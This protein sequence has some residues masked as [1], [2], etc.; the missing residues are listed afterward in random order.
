MGYQRRVHGDT[1]Q[2]NMLQKTLLLC[3]LAVA[4]ATATPLLS[5]G[6]N[7]VELAVATP[8]LS[9]LVTALKAGALVDTLSGEGPFTVFAPTNEAFAK[10]SASILAHLLDPANVK[11]LDAVLEYHVVAGAAVFSN[12]LTDGE[13]IKTVEGQNV[14]VSIYNGRVFI[15]NA[16]VTTADVAAS[17]GVIHIIDTVL[18][19]PPAPAPPASKNIVE[20][21]AASADFSTLV[22][23]LKA[24]GLVDYLSAKGPFTVFAPTNEA[25]AKLPAATLTHLLDPANMK[26]LDALLE[27]HVVSGVAAFVKDLKDEELIK[28]VEGD[29]VSIRVNP[30]GP[31]EPAV[32]I[33]IGSTVVYADIAASN[34]VIHGIDTVLTIPPCPPPAPNMTI[35]EVAATFDE[36]STLVTALKAAD[37]V[38]ALAGPT[39]TIFAP[40]NQAFERLPK[41]TLAHLL[42]PANIKELV[43]LLE[44]HVLP[45]QASA[46]QIIKFSKK[47][48]VITTLEGRTVSV[49]TLPPN[50]LDE[51]ILVINDAFVTTADIRASNGFIH[52]IDTVLTLPKAAKKTSIC[53]VVAATP[54]LSTL[55]TA[56]KATQFN[57]LCE[58]SAPQYPDTLFAPSN[59]AFDRLPKATLAHLL[60]PANVDELSTL[61]EYHVAPSLLPKPVA[62]YSKD[63]T[64]GEKIPTLHVRKLP[65]E[66]NRDKVTVTIDP[67]K[68]IL[69]NDAFV[70][71][72]DIGAYNGVIHII[73]TVLT[74]PTPA[75]AV[76]TITDVA[77]ATPEFATLVTPV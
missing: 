52:I 61:L 51:T 23:A 35:V 65:A 40:T 48:S 75:P 2:A 57:Y 46:E 34:G 42:D 36:L 1:Q 45:E 21:A 11:E 50:S 25:F 73:D 41:A 66:G 77:A 29:D 24:G 27:Y 30:Y 72:A 60:D 44:Y 49:R 18:K 5:T 38:Q 26:E 13:T 6:K 31:D 47:Y 3:A 43:A 4:Y 63:L 67:S 56:L 58:T 10:L 33:N 55:N 71:T 28:T 19:M 22:T 59:A 74:F 53:D 70:T 64:D 12:Y 32:V 54:N 69:I 15:N 20:V 68:N 14:T 76:K 37:P 9:T 16:L 39:L 62:Y 7:I 17:N 8:E